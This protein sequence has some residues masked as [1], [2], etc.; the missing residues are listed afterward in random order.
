MQHVCSQEAQQVRHGQRAGC[1]KTKARKQR[2]VKSFGSA[3]P[4]DTAAVEKLM[5]VATS[6]LQKMSSPTLPHIYEEEDV[7][8]GFGGV[9]AI[10]RAFSSFVWFWWCLQR[11]GLWL[12]IAWGG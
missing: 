9:I 6:F 11:W 10:S 5:Q 3:R 4:D 2:V 8:D 1:P 12:L 7:I